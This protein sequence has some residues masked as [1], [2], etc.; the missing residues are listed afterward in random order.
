MQGADCL[1]LDPALDAPTPA[2]DAAPLP[3]LTLLRDLPARHKLLFGP[4]PCQAGQGD[5]ADLGIEQACDGIEIE[6]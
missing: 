6:V 3:W 2:T 1:L 5:W 4:A